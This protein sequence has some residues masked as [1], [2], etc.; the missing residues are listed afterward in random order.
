MSIQTIFV[1]EFRRELGSG[2]TKPCV[3]SCSDAN[4]ND[5]GEM[6]VKLRGGMET[7]ALGSFAEYTCSLLARY[8]GIACAEPFLVDIDAALSHAIP[9][10]DTAER[11]RKS[12]GLNFAT[13]YLRHGLSEWIPTAKL[14]AQER[15]QALNI[16]AFDA[17]IQNIDRHTGKPNLLVK[18]DALTVIDHE[19]AFSFAL[20][21]FPR[22]K[23]WRVQHDDWLRKHIFF[24][25]LQHSSPDWNALNKKFQQMHTESIAEKIITSVPSAWSDTHTDKV[26]P[27]LQAMLTHTD[28]F[29]HDLNILLL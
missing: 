17:F 7:P 14:T 27:H 1:T 24:R 10:T 12:I 16:F 2:R 13:T 9:Q 6:V 28:E 4:G 20:A 25:H 29:F 3:F 26:L 19:L 5:V 22:K 18:N 11:V 21:L 8:L 15:P 23:I